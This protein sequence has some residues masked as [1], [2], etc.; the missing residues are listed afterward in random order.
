MQPDFITIAGAREHNL[1][2]LTVRIPRNRLTAITGPSG[3]G[4]SSLAFDTLYAEGQRRYVESLSAYARQFL[5]RLRK[6]DVDRIDGLSP[7]IAV[8]QRTAGHTP[9]STVATSTEIHDHLRLLFAAAGRPHCPVCDRLLTRHSA[10]EIVESLLTLPPR[11]RIHL[12]APVDVPQGR[13]VDWTEDIRRSGFVRIRADGQWRDLDEIAPGARAP[14]QV[15]AVVDRLELTGDLRA[16][17]TDSVELALR[18]GGGAASARIEPPGGPVEERLFSA[19]HSCLACGIRYEPLTAQSFSFNSPY[20]ACPVCH[21]LGIM[22]IFDEAKVL[23]NLNLSLEKGAVHAWRFGGRSLILYYKRLLRS[24]AAHYAVDPELPY[25]ELPEAFR[26]ILLHGSGED[27]VRAAGRGRARAVSK[28]FEGVIPNLERRFRETESPAVRERLRRFMVQQPC[29]GCRGARLRPESVACR[30]DGQSIADL[31]ALSVDAL[32]AR[33]E[34]LRLDPTRE[35]LVRDLLRE[36]GHR[37]CF[38][39]D[40]GLGYLTLDRGSGSLSGGEAQ[41]IRLASH[42]GAGLSGVL[43]VLDEPSIGLHARDHA[44]LLTTLQALRDLGNTVVVVEHDEQTIRKSDYVVDLGPGAGPHGGEVLYAGDSAGLIHSRDSLSAQYLRGDRRIEI[45]E[46]RRTAHPG[47]LIIRGAG[48]NNLK[49]I[50]ARFPLGCFVCVTGVSGSGKS[51]LVDDIL[52]RAL[53]RKFG[54]SGPEPGRHTGLEGLEHIDQAV[55]IDQAPIGRTPRSNPA[56][57][58]G[59]FGVIRDL[60]S[61]LPAAKVRGYR[62][63]RFSFNA[64]GGRCERCRGDGM[65]KVEMHF[66]PDVY[67]PCDLCQGRRYNRQTLEI[68][69]GGRTIADVLDLTIDEAM[70]VYQRVPALARRIRTLSEVGLGYL[71]LGQ[72]ATTLSGGEA[73]RIKLAAELSRRDTGRTLY[74]LDEPTTGLHSEDVR[75][76]LAVLDR[77]TDAG[78]TVLVIEHHLDVIKRADWV[79]DLGPEGGDAGGRI[80][81]EGTPEAIAACPDSHTGV[82]LSALLS[83]SAPQA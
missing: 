25:R 60:F 28:P 56:T 74:I 46:R 34:T 3:S 76:L 4:K 1:K 17:L 59:A 67:V 38:L 19:K 21:G 69:Y 20:G 71:R 68:R 37:L 78:N 79:L 77:L 45:P 8:E 15:E 9:R 6:P 43:Y 54:G 72:P 39:R 52:R 29:T 13:G 18:A 75:K 22:E 42:L 55:V 40:V 27:P 41:R 65:L 30:V 14:A 50:D 16:R 2:N 32:S 24:L 47:W 44:R 58:T 66:L 61:R 81:A 7:A 31:C 33:L 62:P 36:I 70:E 57:Y 80:V 23:P 63:G 53:A 82:Y 12:L 51:S 35:R 64:R 5:D 73:Q 48:A 49:G 83:R 11:S 26:R 10:E